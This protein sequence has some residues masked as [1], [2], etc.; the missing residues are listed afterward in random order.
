MAN[1]VCLLKP[2]EAANFEKYGTV[3]CCRNHKH[4]KKVEAMSLTARGGN[5][6]DAA[7]ARWIGSGMIA[8][9]AQG[10]WVVRQSGYAGPLVMQMQ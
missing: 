1:T 8:L 3:P 4:I 6:R 5:V 7:S 9:I 10:K 2:W